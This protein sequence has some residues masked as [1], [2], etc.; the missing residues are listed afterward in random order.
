MCGENYSRRRR[1]YGALGSPPRV[2][3]KRLRIS[4]EDGLLR[5][6]PACAGKTAAVYRDLT[7]EKDHP[8]VCGENFHVKLITIVRIGSPPR[9]RGKQKIIKFY[10]E[11]KRITPACAGKTAHTERPHGAGKD[12]PRV[13]GENP[14]EKGN[15]TNVRGS[16][17]RVR[18][19]LCATIGAPRA[20]RIT[21]ACAGKTPCFRYNLRLRRDHP[22]VCGENLKSSRRA[23]KT[24]GSPPRVRGKLSEFRV[25]SAH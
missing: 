22:R 5:I 20:S 9:V 11:R 24:V 21:P 12:H 17:P 10:D 13:C 18:G 6:T 16:P 25:F 4:A 2:R 15:R 8:R 23:L 14:R 3:G 19:K 7:G 1:R